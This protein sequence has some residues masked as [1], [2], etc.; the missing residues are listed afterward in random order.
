MFGN[1]RMLVAFTVATLATVG[2]IAVLAAERWALLPIPLIAHAVASVLVFSVLGDALK[3]QDKDDPV[4]EAHR[5][6]EDRDE[7]S[8]EGEGTGPKMAI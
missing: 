6:A 2:L 3:K 8:G 7:T 4:A 1:P 5:E